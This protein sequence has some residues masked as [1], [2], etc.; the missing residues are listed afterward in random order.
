MTKS[1][2]W[3]RE[4]HKNHKNDFT[5]KKVTISKTNY[6]GIF[7]SQSEKLVQNESFLVTKAWNTCFWPLLEPFWAILEL[8]C[9]HQFPNILYRWS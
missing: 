6:F 8:I 3:N 4:N 1:T 5:Y 9:A 2:S 7:A